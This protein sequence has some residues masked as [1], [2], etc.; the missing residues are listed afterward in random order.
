MDNIIFSERKKREALILMLASLVPLLLGV[1]YPLV[2]DNTNPNPF[3]PN[4]L[5]AAMMYCTFLF[6]FLFFCSLDCIRYEL[7]V[8][9]QTITEITLLK[10]KCINLS[11]VDKYW[12][13]DSIRKGYNIV[14]MRANGKV[15]AVRTQH[16]KELIEL[17]N[18]CGA[19]ELG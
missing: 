19:V 8:T 4:A 17:L 7:T 14:V 15:L 3:N 12:V 5:R 11:D 2:R 9:T 18:S 13:K 1:V 6:F 16:S 10:K